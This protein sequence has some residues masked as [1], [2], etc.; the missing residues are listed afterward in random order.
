[1]GADLDPDAGSL[2]LLDDVPLSHDEV[3]Y[4]AALGPQSAERDGGPVGVS[5]ARG[6]PSPPAM[7]RLA[8]EAFDRRA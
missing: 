2:A 5:C 7:A 4:L 1:M 6:R 8:P 3:G